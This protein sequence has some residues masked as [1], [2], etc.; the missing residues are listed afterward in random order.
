ML[1][2]SALA[3]ALALLCWPEAGAR[4]RLGLLPGPAGVPLWAAVLRGRRAILLATFLAAVLAVAMLGPAVTAAL[5]LLAGAI[6]WR[7]RSRTRIKAE[8][9]AT[10]ALAEA[11]RTMV[12]E[13]RTGAH[14]S[15]AAESA[16]TDAP[17]GVANLLG[18]IAASARL[19]GELDAALLAER[20]PLL[21]DGVPGQLARAWSLARDHGLPLAG[22][23]EAVQRDV[24]ANVRLAGQVH[25]RMAGPRA[26]AGILAA[27]PVA[28]VALGEA[29]G[30]R[31]LAVLLTVP[32]GQLLLVAGC[33]LI[34]AGVAWSA[35]LTGRV[36]R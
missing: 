20:A 24:D 23:L 22:V 33:A 12:A 30:A 17:A 5:V 35:A 28:G 18:T 14:P 13:L 31:P 10:E 2:L 36:V 16:A 32:I 3:A 15:A 34:F 26:S 25:A 21:G 7:S 6:C 27:L 1:I 29:M 9:G 11:L 4:R 19:G 8:L